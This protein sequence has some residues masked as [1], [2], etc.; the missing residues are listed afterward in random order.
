MNGVRCVLLGSAACL[1]IGAAPAQAQAT[2]ANETAQ[3][4]PSET[5]A[6]T[7]PDA[8]NAIVVT[9]QRREENL[10]DVPIA[11][12]AF[13][14]DE[15]EGKAIAAVS[16]L[17]FAAPSLSLQVGILGKDP[18]GRNLSRIRRQGRVPV[19]QE[20]AGRKKGLQIGPTIG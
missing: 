4:T 10:Q 11:A 12:T 15:L 8:L 17:Q 5:D 7:A 19:V 9:A 2:S 13:A 16:D 14:G 20:R 6:Q 3:E 1:A 18:R